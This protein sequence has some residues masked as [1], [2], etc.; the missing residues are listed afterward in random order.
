[1]NSEPEL[2]SRISGG[3]QA[4]LFGFGKDVYKLYGSHVRPRDAKHMAIREARV[5]KIVEDFDD[6]PAPRVLGVRQ[7]E[8]RWVCT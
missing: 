3:D 6:V 2:G 8:G 1:M 5:L 4:E 7:I